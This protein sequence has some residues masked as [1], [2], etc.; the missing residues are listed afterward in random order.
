MHPDNR[1]IDHLHGCVMRGSWR[2]DR[3]ANHAKAASAM[4]N[5]RSARRCVF[6]QKELRLKASYG[7][8]DG[9]YSQ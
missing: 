4:M 9:R 7:L 6:A 3:P 1:R 5:P 2:V 8:Q